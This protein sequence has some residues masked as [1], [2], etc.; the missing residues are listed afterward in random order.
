MTNRIWWYV[1]VLRITEERIPKN[2][3]STKTKWNAQEVDKNKIGTT[4]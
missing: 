4:R 1:R 2:G 3:L